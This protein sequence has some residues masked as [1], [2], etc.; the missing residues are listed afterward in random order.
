[1][2]AW[3][4]RSGE[5]RASV[6][7]SKHVFWSAALCVPGWDAMPVRC[8]GRPP[9]AQR[10]GT[11]K[12]RP[13]CTRVSRPRPRPAQ[14]Q[15]SCLPCS[16]CAGARRAWAG[17]AGCQAWPPA[18]CPAGACPGPT[19]HGPSGRSLLRIGTIVLVNAHPLPAPQR[20]PAR[21]APSTNRV[22]IT[23]AGV[24]QARF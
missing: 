4:S 22:K 19:A 3:S 15:S 5:T 14:L 24:N 23:N 16:V 20:P 18:A 6:C 12:C 13:G 9:V 17:W 11:P 10:P 21:G 7:S 1:M 2:P 8:L